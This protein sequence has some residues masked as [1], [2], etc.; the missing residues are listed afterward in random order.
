MHPHPSTSAARGGLRRSTW[1]WCW[2]SGAK[3]W[4]DLV[5]WAH[6]PPM[7]VY[8]TAL[9]PVLS[10]AHGRGWRRT[11]CPC[12]QEVISKA[13]KDT[14]GCSTWNAVTS[15]RLLCCFARQP[16]P[17]PRMPTWPPMWDLE[18]S[19]IHFFFSFERSGDGILARHHEISICTSERIQK[20]ESNTPEP[21]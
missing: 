7:G 1:R 17:W 19:S 6:R 12:K 5:V 16:P 2:Y 20:R 9:V 18:C 10:H 11:F 14:R 8:R 3:S 13:L 15:A 21:T 4:A